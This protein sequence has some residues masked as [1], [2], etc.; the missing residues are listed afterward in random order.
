LNKFGRIA[1][2]T[3]L[4][5]IGSIIALLLLVIF[6]IRLP[7]VQNYVVGKVTNYVENK[8]HTP[9]RIGYIH[10][11]FPTKLVLENIYFEDQSRDTL[12]A[13]EKLKVDISMFKLLKNTVEIQ[14][15]SL[16]GITAK[17]NR[18]L[19]DSTFNFDYIIDAFVTQKESTTAAPDTSSALIFDLDKVSFEKIHFVYSDEVIGTSADISLQEF[20]TRIKTFDLK[21]NMTFD[22]PNV[23]LHGV[24]AVVKQWS[25]LTASNAPKASDFGIKDASVQSSELLPNIHI[26]T[27]DLAN[28]QVRYEDASSQMKTKFIVQKF[29]AN[30]NEIDLNKE[31]VDL[32]EISLEG[33]DSEILFGKIAKKEKVADTS[34]TPVNWVVSAK[35]VSINKTAL[36]FKDDNQA[37]MKGF[38]YGNIKISDFNGEL[39]Q[40]Y[41]SADSISGSLKNLSAKDHSG[42][43]LKKLQG[44]FYYRN[45][46]AE[47]KNL[48]AE[49]PHTIFR[50][51]IRI[52]YPSLDIIAQ[53]PELIRV[54][55]NIKKSHLGMKDVY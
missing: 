45:T 15:L 38:D 1:L 48:Y 18:T 19:P 54:H 21:S 32:E 37:R 53:K 43:Q 46:G 5:V 4:W 29:L 26:K 34:A 16:H 49:T 40:L 33:S 35:K 14:D 51:Y 42:F 24:N 30:I 7:S 44:D 20:S 23:K 10:I 25:P 31:F 12:L 39:S 55:A 50:D 27:A 2:K 47:I 17:I 36:W 6:L 3:I 8:I 11:E 41:Y 22:M 28:I 13:G 52:D 9:V